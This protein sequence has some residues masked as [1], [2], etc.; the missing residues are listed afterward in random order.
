LF[1]QQN[2]D[3]RDFWVMMMLATGASANSQ[4]PT[5][6]HETDGADQHNGIKKV[7]L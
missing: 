4:Q 2:C 7:S 1:E 3:G 5:T 6:N